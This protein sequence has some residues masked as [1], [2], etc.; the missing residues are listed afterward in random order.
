M[1]ATCSA[2]ARCSW[3]A[4]ISSRTPRSS[5]API[6]TPRASPR[7]SISI[8]WRGSIASSAPISIS[9]PSSTTPSYNGE[10]SRIEMHLA[11]TKRQKVR[12]CDTHDRVSRRRNHP[13]REQLQIYDRLL[14]GAG[15]RQRLVAAHRYGRDGLFSVHALRIGSDRCPNFCRTPASTPPAVTVRMPI[16]RSRSLASAVFCAR[17]DR[18]QYSDRG[19]RRLAMVPGASLGLRQARCC[20]EP[21]SRRRS[22]RH[23]AAALSGL[24]QADHQSEGHG[25]RQPRAASQADYERTTRRAISG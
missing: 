13:H 15:A 18:G 9:R 2:T 3:S 16:M 14:S 20:A 25:H 11:S 5:I 6:T 21:E 1:P 17:Q 23:A 7:N 24:L 22:A 10:R 19:Q 8:C 4:S 12:V